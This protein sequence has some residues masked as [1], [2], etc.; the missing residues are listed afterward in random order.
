[1]IQR[2]KVHVLPV[3]AGIDPNLTDLLPGTVEYGNRQPLSPLGPFDTVAVAPG[4]FRVAQVVIEDE[5]ICMMDLIKE[6]EPG[7]IPR[8]QGSHNKIFKGFLLLHGLWKRKRFIGT[9]FT[10]IYLC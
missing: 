7:K 2:S 9:S 1:M 4:F 8:L 3:P 6:T 5:D 10:L